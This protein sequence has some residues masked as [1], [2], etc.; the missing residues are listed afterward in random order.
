MNKYQQA[1]NNYSENV[2]YRDYSTWDL[3]VIGNI[4]E[5][6]ELLENE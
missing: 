2:D 1:L 5:N 4:Y 6:K 3:K